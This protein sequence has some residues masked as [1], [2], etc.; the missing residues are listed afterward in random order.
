M[1]TE[2]SLY[3]LFPGQGQGKR[4]YIKHMTAAFVVGVMTAGLLA[5]AI[6]YMA[7]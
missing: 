1:S 7:Q 2:K 6:Y 5:A 4:K 3:Y